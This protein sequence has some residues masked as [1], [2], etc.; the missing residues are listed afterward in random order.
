MTAE[1]TQGAPWRIYRGTGEPH[2]DIRRL[3]PP[4]PW[5]SFQGGPLIEPVED[6]DAEAAARLDVIARS[7]RPEEA[8]IELVNAAL[9]LRRPLLVTGKPGVGK[10][11]LAHSM[12]RELGLGPVLHWPITS[13]STLA[14]GLY[15]YDAIGRLQHANL[16]KILS[17]RP[18]GQP[19][20]EAAQDDDA[21]DIG[22]YIRLGPLGT[23]LL[24][25]ALPRVLLIDEL[26]KSDIDLPNDLLNIFENGEF[27]IT[28]LSRLPVG[29]ATKVLTASGE[30]RAEVRRGKVRCAAFPVVVITSNGEREFP[31]AFLRRCIRLDVQ[32]P[33]ERRLAE[34]VELQLGP[35]AL[36]ASGA[37][38]GRFLERRL[39]HNVATDQLLNA[40]YL[41]T[42]RQAGDQGGGLNPGLEEALLRPLG[43][44]ER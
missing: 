21:A 6:D 12:A 8:T 5:R 1:P 3:P 22:R 43:G 38:I 9:Y 24:P 44:A 19:A 33:D 20:A 36:A 29:P 34:I 10:S 40:I 7:Y 25:G 41:A 17:D 26:D 35:E 18:G 14:D 37:I 42:S 13:R 32:P 23:A 27:E 39:K 28:E 31:G 11:S 15:Q 4:P 16:R 2:D 30:R